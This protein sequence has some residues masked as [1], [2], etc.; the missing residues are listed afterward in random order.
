MYHVVSLRVLSGLLQVVPVADYH[1]QQL[2]SFTN[3][4]TI[5]WDLSSNRID[6]VYSLWLTEDW[7]GRVADGGNAS[8]IQSFSA[9]GQHTRQTFPRLDPTLEY[10]VA[11]S[12]YLGGFLSRGKIT[13]ETALLMPQ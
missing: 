7:V 3:V 11:V 9:V 8:C 5:S 13:G 12:F 10:I 4:T 1:P 2:F 6:P